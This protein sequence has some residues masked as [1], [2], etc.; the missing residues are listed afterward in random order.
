[1]SGLFD[2]YT[3]KGVTLR[4]R[5]AVS[6]MCQYSAID[7]V[8]ND[9]HYTHL[10]SLARGGSSLVIVEA[11]GVS[12]EGRITPG[13][14][15]LWNETQAA[16]MQQPIAEI[17]K[18]GAV[19]GI[20][21]AHAGRKASA[22]SP[23]EGD[24]HIPETDS[25]AWQPIGPS[26]VAYGHILSREPEEMTLDDIERVKADFVASTKRALDL[27]YEWLMLHFAHGYLAQNF[28]SPHSN[29][30]TDRYGGSLENRARFMNETLEAVREIWPDNLPL[31][32]RMGVIEY[33]DRE[34]TLDESISVIRGF[35]DRGL[36]FLDVSVGFSTPDA[37]IPFG[38]NFMA[39]VASQI[40]T[41]VDIPVSCSWYINDPAAAN[42]MIE[43]EE[44]DLVM[45]GR[46]LLENPHW[47]YQAAR[48]LG[49]D[50]PSWTLPA[51]YAH[52]LERY[53]SSNLSFR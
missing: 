41:A 27:G 37:N 43:N 50:K 16:A 18:Y 30:R 11:T 47:P 52:W 1:M 22:N 20:Q 17:K 3:L 25:R 44:L 33:D 45:L 35:K 12:P 14:V 48:E 46:I 23:W 42:A 4:N 34:E 39:P 19:P 24:D 51:P 2:S 29:Q 31:S 36:D 6:P 15:G 28:L 21:L 9:W 10:S 32:A 26:K 38:P 40:R 5:I 13:C 49:I 7:G 8:M 53:R